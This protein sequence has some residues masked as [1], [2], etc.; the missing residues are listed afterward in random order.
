MSV[1]K[2]AASEAQ[3]QRLGAMTAALDEVAERRGLVPIFLT[4]TLPPRW[5]P[6]PKMGRRTWTQDLSPRA[7]DDAMRRVWMRFRARLAKSKIPS[8]GLR[9]W[10]PHE[11]GCPHIHALLYIKEEQIET[12]DRHLRAVCPDAAGARR[13]VASRL[14]VIDRTRA[15]GA[16]YV[17]KYLRKTVNSAIAEDEGGQDPL[18]EDDHLSGDHH[19]RTRAWAS[20]RRIRRYAILGA[21]GMQRIWQRLRTAGEDEMEGAPPRV[22]E[23]K[24]A[25]DDHRWAD[26]LEAIGAIR[27]EPGGRL[28]IGYETET[29]DQ[30]T[31]EVTAMTNKYGEPTKRA[32]WVEDTETAG[33][34]LAVGRGG[35]IE[36]VELKA[37]DIKAVTVNDTF[38][39]AAAAP[40]TRRPE[41]PSGQFEATV[42]TVIAARR[43]DPQWHDWIRRRQE[44]LAAIKTQT[45][46]DDESFAVAA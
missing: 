3:M 46:D 40:S 13:R 12:V 38:P 9:V 10:E 28:R 16:T 11:D 33:W 42:S 20:E 14:V 21:H 41:E 22:I 25:M 8:L 43:G 35:T 15:R 19:D 23:A 5:H 27:G 18:G 26:A 45:A 31:G 34:K 7:A 2:K 44:R 24:A 37:N 4:L 39:R 36:R 30:T 29:V 1:I 6:N 32:A 17:M